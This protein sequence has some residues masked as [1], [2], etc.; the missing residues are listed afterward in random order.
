MGSDKDLSVADMAAL[1]QEI[2]NHRPKLLAMVRRRIDPR[3]L[4]ASILRKSSARHSFRRA[5]NGKPFVR[6]LPSRPMHGCTASSWTAC[7]QHGPGRPG[8][9]AI[10]IARCSGP[11]G[12]RCNSA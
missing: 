7:W 11:S 10:F 6:T 12:R 4:F 2:E 3:W 1:G 8:G 5:A 9:G